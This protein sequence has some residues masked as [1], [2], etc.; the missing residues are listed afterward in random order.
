MLLVCRGP[1]GTC[2]ESRFVR[3]ARHNIV[4][5]KSDVCTQ[6]ACFVYYLRAELSGVRYDTDRS[7]HTP[8]LCNV[9]AGAERSRQGRARD[10]GSRQGLPSCAAHVGAVRVQREGLGGHT[11][12]WVR[13]KPLLLLLLLLWSCWRDGMGKLVFQLRPCVLASQ[14][15]RGW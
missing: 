8:P 3:D 14:A 9:P 15:R 13:G 6:C 4:L 7:L 11:A 2:V 1:Q 12:E 10:Q 5:G